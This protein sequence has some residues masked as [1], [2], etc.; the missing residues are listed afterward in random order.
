[1]SCCNGYVNKNPAMHFSGAYHITS[2][3][4]KTQ[5]LGGARLT[6][7]RIIYNISPIPTELSIN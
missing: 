2:P 1:M 5:Y 4:Q 6:E 3:R 7:T